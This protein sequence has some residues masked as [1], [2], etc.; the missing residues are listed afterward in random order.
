MPQESLPITALRMAG[1]V[2]LAVAALTVGSRMLRMWSRTH[3]LPELA[4]GSHILILITGYSLEFS[5][6][7]G[8]E[9]LGPDAA[10]ALR[11]GG[12]LAYALSIV[13]YL[14]FSWRVFRPESR[15][16]AALVVLC[17]LAL[18]VG[19]TG[20]LVTGRFEL[21]PERFAKP[22]FWIAF[23][24]R[25][26]CM[27]WSAVEGLTRWRLLR[28]RVRIGLESPL[29]ANRFLCWGLA[30][31]AE[32]MIYVVAGVALLGPRPTDFLVGPAALLISAMGVAASVTILLAFLPPPAWQRWLESRA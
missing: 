28:R 13:A 9:T 26:V 32:V 21:V 18:A 8:A 11:A 23:V 24:P 4:L 3:R 22:W 2:A 10:F 16:A 14:L 15:W 19:W 6:L 20:E 25:I 27:G 29:L 30:A 1:F 7:S 17:T 12:N 5:G 31:L